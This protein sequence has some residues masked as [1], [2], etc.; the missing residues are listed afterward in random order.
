MFKLNNNFE[1]WIFLFRRLYWSHVIA[2]TEPVNRH[3]GAGGSA[4]QATLGAAFQQA[5]EDL[6]FE[7]VSVGG[8]GFRMCL[9]L[10][11]LFCC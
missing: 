2:T 9:N 10:F 3:L 8:Q 1:F 7:T 6:G 5:A 11:K 4:A